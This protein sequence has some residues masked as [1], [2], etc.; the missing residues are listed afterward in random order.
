MLLLR[1]RSAENLLL[2]SAHEI[3]IADFGWS[4]HAPSQ[5]RQ[6]MCGTLDYLAPEMI[7]H[8]SHDHN[9]DL[10]CLGILL[11]EFL[12]GG[13]PFESRETKDT[14][15]RIMA[16]DIKWPTKFQISNEAKDLVCS[17]LKIQGSERL[18]LVKV[19]QHPFILK[20]KAANDAL[21]KRTPQA[22]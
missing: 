6:T 12:T 13:P 4:V 17:L 16:L 8:R 19:A 14:Y 18:P 2:S 22:S 11:F 3:K 20:Y 5:R 10:W 21:Y 9:V 1:I 15:K 7:S